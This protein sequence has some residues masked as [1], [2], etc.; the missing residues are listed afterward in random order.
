MNDLNDDGAH[1]PATSVFEAPEKS[2]DRGASPTPLSLPASHDTPTPN[3]LLE[4]MV[5]DWAVRAADP[6]RTIT[7]YA[8]FAGRRRALSQLFPTDTLVI[9]TGHEKVRSNDTHYRFRP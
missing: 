3:A 2:A 8:A 9:P 1:A 5:Q 4:F 7:G 6:T